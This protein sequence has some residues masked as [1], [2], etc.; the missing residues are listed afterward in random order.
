MVFRSPDRGL[1]WTAISSDLTTNAKRDDIV[2]MGVKNTD[3]RI[4]RNDGIAAWPAIVSLAESPKRP[5]LIYTG[6]DDGVLSVTKDGGKTWSNV[7]G[8]VPGVPAGIFVSEVVPSR[9]DENAVYA[10]FDGH[11]QNDFGTYIYASNDAGQTWRSIAAN[12]KDEV[13]RTLT[14]DLKNPDVLYL[15]TETGLFVSTDRGKNWARIKANLPAVRIDEITLHPRD[16]A[17]LLATHGRAIWILDNLAPIQEYAAA[18]AAADAKL[19]SPPPAAMFR[20][21]ARD[22]NYEFWGDQTFFGQNPPQAAVITWFLKRQ[23]DKVALKITDAAGKDVREISGQMLASSNTVGIQAACWDLRVQPLEAPQIAAAPGGRG[24]GQPGAQAGAAGAGRGGGPGG[25]PASP[26]GAGC[27]AAGGGFGGGGFGGGA[28]TAGPYVLPGIYNVS[29]IVDGKTV[30]AKPLRVTADPEVALSPVDRQRMFDMA[31]EMHSLQR[32]ATDVQTA[33]RPL[34]SRMTELARE[35]AGR[36]DVPAEVKATFEAF[37]KDLTA[38]APKFAPAAFGRGGGAGPAAAP[39][40]A[41]A[42]QPAAPPQVNLITRI[43][44][45]KNGLMATMPPTEQTTKA[46]TEA[47]A[48]VP[49]AILEANALFARADALSKALAPFKLALTAPAPV[50]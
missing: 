36:N 45:A 14:E 4:A 34:T 25:A 46:Y 3:T 24:E 22:R 20:R 18:Q 12:L 42:G 8:K 44:Q 5:G 30:E 17:M 1:T 27:G 48:Q 37:N 29:L 32:R 38:F 39:A 21:P 28:A 33:L 19:F 31:M 10:T 26:F 2:T 16:N 11:R 43:G 7:F 9:F 13:A 41:Q 47:K 50:K 6:T 23:A 40:A 35:I 15:G 49:K